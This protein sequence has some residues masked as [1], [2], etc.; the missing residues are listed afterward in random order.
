[1]S[2]YQVNTCAEVSGA[3]ITTNDLTICPN[4]TTQLTVTNTAN[5]T[6][7]WLL[8]GNTIPNAL[9]NTVSANQAGNYSVLVSNS[10]LGCVDTTNII[11]VTSIAPPSVSSGADQTVCGG[12]N[13]TLNA[14]GASSYVWNNGSS[15]NTLSIATGSSTSTNAYIV[16]GTD[17]TTGCSKKDT[18]LIIVN[19]L[20][21]INAGNDFNAC[22][23]TDFDLRSK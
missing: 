8:N 11:T 14:T 4:Q 2:I 16:T 19:G 20:P 12:V 17:V 22:N 5:V 10:T 13:V 23:N 18:V 9:G 1:L 3:P 21:Q 15:S 6:Y 7:E